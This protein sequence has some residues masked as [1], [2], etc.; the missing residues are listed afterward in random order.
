[1]IINVAICVFTSNLRHKRTT[2]GFVA[3][4]SL[5]VCSEFGRGLSSSLISRKLV[6]HRSFFSGCLKPMLFGQ[7]VTLQ[8]LFLLEA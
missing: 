5:F 8:R 4:R 6:L 2:L 3:R 1:M 7:P